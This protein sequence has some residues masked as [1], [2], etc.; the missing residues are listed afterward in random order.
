MSRC[1]LTFNLPERAHSE[2]VA[3]D[4][5]SDFDSAFVFGFLRRHR[6]R[7][8]LASQ[9]SKR[10]AVGLR[11]PGSERASAP[12]VVGGVDAARPDVVQRK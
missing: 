4:V 5:V 10:R 7:S 2:R 11:A 3:E 1:L 8:G 12:H 6:S 9:S